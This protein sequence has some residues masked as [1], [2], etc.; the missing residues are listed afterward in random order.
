M[1][2]KML[3]ALGLVL[4]AASRSSAMSGPLPG[5]TRSAV[6]QTLFPA[7]RTLPS[8]LPRDSFMQKRLTVL[9][10]KVSAERAEVERA[11]REIAALEKLGTRNA[12][13]DAVEEARKARVQQLRVEAGLAESRIRRLKAKLGK[14]GEVRPGLLGW[15]ARN[16]ETFLAAEESSA[17]VLF[18]QLLRTKA[19]GSDPWE[20]VRADTTSLL[21]L[22]SNL[23]LAAGY[24]QLSQS[25]RLVPHAAAIVARANKLERHAPGILLAVEPYLELIEP[26]LDP[27]LDRFDEI[28]PHLPFVLDHLEELAPHCGVLLKHFDSLILY[29]D[30]D[31]TYLPRLIG[32][33]PTFAPLFDKLGPHLALLRPHL[34][35]LL[36]H[37][38][39]IAPAAERFAPY[40]AVSANADVLLWCAA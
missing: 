13:S 9:R 34:P 37:L 17:R 40:V 8:W 14:N 5:G 25:P 15:L 33:L 11:A 10:W 39:V 31:E 27:I 1:I 35:R 18:S 3:T 30:E 16:L 4:L 26:H 19:R 21:R 2:R 7:A 6:I 22:G 20:L 36:P 28:E 38:P 32:Y 24:L 29:A 12:S 23:T